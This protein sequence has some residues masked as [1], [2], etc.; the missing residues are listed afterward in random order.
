MP[1]AMLDCLAGKFRAAT[2]G[3][4]STFLTHFPNGNKDVADKSAV[5]VNGSRAGVAGMAQ[6]ATH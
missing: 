4:R 1:A 2:L 3:Q 5:T 6:W